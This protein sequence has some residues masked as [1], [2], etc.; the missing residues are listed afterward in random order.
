MHHT[1]FIPVI[2]LGLTA[3]TAPA[4]SHLALPD[5]A[6]AFEAGRHE[7]QIGAGVFISVQN[8]SR[9]RPQIDDADG[10]LRYGWMLTTPAGDGFWRG[11]TELLVSAFGAGI[12]KGP[13]S[14]LAGG[15]LLLRQNFVQPHARWVPYLQIEAGCLYS[16]GYRDATQGA[17]GNGFEFAL[18]GGVGLRCLWDERWAAFAEADYRHISNA[19][20]GDRNLGTNAVGGVVGVSWLF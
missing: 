19:G 13:G 2:A 9:K 17:L 14:V 6:G 15:T 18:G 11:N 5:A 4:G 12:Y 20:L 16:D 10:L 1:L 7:L 8:T 3:W